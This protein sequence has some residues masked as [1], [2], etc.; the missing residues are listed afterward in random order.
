MKYLGIDFGT[1]RIGLSLS[2]DDGKVAFPLSVISNDSKI[3]SVI[4]EICKDKKVD[5]IVIGESKDFSFNDNPVMEDIKVFVDKLK[6]LDL[7]VE[8]HP[9]FLTS[10]EA[11]RVT[12]KNK[13]TDSSASAIILQ[14]YLDKFKN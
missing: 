2:D 3:D 1:K 6:S 13:M 5:I 14:S 8:F 7:K 12:G 4:L 10:M 11:K 9:E